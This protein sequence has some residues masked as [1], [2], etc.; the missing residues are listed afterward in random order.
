MCRRARRAS[1][2]SSAE[3]VG[4]FN[5]PIAPLFVTM[6]LPTARYPEVKISAG[7]KRWVRGEESWEMDIRIL[8]YLTIM[9]GAWRTALWS[10][11]RRR[12]AAILCGLARIWVQD[13]I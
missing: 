10:G 11:R 6:I 9:N 12:A 5:V 2:T 13:H 7:R 3:C 8:T 1:F 4:S